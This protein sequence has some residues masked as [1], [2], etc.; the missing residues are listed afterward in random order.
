MEKEKREL[1]EQ[2]TMDINGGAMHMVT[3]TPLAGAGGGVPL[4][5]DFAQAGLEYLKP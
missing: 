5:S 2:E 4:W 3:E 1:T